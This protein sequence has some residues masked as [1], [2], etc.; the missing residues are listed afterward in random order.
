MGYVQRS[1]LLAACLPFFGCASTQ[2]AWWDDRQP[3]GHSGQEWTQRYTIHSFSRNHANVQRDA[4][5]QLQRWAEWKCPAGYKTNDVRI[6]EKA[7][8]PPSS[9]LLSLYYGGGLGIRKSLSMEMDITCS[10]PGSTFAE[11]TKAAPDKQ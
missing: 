4:T 2:T 8:P 5:Q 3:Q 10:E 7:P 1:M 6:L 11:N 9:G